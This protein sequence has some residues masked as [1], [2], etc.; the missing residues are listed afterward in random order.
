MFALLVNMIMNIMRKIV[1]TK[2][3]E[4]D[5][6]TIVAFF[7]VMCILLYFAVK[8]VANEQLLKKK[9]NDINLVPSDLVFTG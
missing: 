1:L 5:W 7:V 9:Y 6:L 3:T 2:C 8:V 4:G